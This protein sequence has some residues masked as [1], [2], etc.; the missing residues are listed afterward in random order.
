M[1]NHIDMLIF[2]NP[3]KEDLA[4][5]F[6]AKTNGSDGRRETTFVAFSSPRR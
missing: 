5:C 2:H 4:I 1:K 3:L 6:W